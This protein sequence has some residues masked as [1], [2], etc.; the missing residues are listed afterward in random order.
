M[1]SPVRYPRGCGRRRH[2][3]PASSNCEEASLAPRA[4]A[5]LLCTGLPWHHTGGLLLRA[6]PRPSHAPAL[7]LRAGAMPQPH[8]PAAVRRARGGGSRPVC[9]PGERGEAR[10]PLLCRSPRVWASLARPAPTLPPR[11]SEVRALPRQVDR[12]RPPPLASPRGQ[13]RR[14]Q[15]HRALQAL[16]QR[17]DGALRWRLRAP[18]PPSAPV[19]TLP[20]HPRAGGSRIAG[21]GRRPRRGAATRAREREILGRGRLPGTPSRPP[22][23]QNGA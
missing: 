3:I 11:A 9:T 22:L 12:G 1:K 21:G 8:A 23:A 4:P 7:R 14:A 19:S 15:P 17:E 18:A 5:S 10:P 20:R 2:R 16:P 6:P 13:R